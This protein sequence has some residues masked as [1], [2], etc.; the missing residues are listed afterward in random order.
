MKGNFPDSIT[1]VVVRKLCT[2]SK[3]KFIKS[4]E[5]FKKS[6]LKNNPKYILKI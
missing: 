3:E 1:N 4:C 6:G 5:H 2:N